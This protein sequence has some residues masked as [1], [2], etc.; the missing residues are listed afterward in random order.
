MTLENFVELQGY[1]LSLAYDS[2]VLEFVGS[3]VGEDNLLGEAALALPQV[4]NLQDGKASIFALGETAVNGDLGLSLVFR[5]KLETEGSYIEITDGLLRDGNYGVNSL[6][7]PAS[8]MIETRPE[9]YALNDNYPNPF[10]PE[11]TIKYQLPEAGLVTLEVYNMLGQVVKTLVSENQT[12]GR[13]TVQWDA[14]NDNGQSLSSGMYFYHVE[15]GEGF[16]DTKKMLL[17][18]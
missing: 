15:A 14:T 2:E 10:N 9:V 18:K 4:I 8:V 3:R 13:K 5:T 17:L 11:T 1:G 6:R 16:Q 7:G 12:A